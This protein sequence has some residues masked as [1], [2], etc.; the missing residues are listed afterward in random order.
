MIATN[1][2]ELGMM[3]VLMI[4]GVCVFSVIAGSLSSLMSN[5]DNAEANLNEKL[6]KLNKLRD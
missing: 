4:A 3:V 1:I 6:M 2:L 5:I